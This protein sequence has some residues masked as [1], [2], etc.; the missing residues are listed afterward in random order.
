MG[1][2][3]RASRPIWARNLRYSSTT[4]SKVCSTVADKVHL[5]D[6]D[7]DLLDAEQAEE[8]AVPAAL[9]AD[10]F[11][12]GDEQHRGIRAGGAG[13]HVLEEFLVSRRIDD[14][15]GADGGLELNLRGV[16]GNVLLL[17]LEQSVQQEGEFEFHPLFPAC[18][19]DLFDLAI[20]QRVGV[21]ENATDQ[22]RFSVVHVADEDDLEPVRPGGRGNGRKSG[23]R[24]VGM[25]CGRF[26]QRN[27]H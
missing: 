25:G 18:L 12:G 10:A 17:L 7:E 26:W 3:V 9:L 1:T 21:V 22:G 13:D 16:D 6:G 24:G 8:V 15:V 14:D 2:K 27:G 11:V 19:P 4:S 23:L 20:G 5:V